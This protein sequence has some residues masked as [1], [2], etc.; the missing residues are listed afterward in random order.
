LPGPLE[1][2]GRP[3]PATRARELNLFLQ[4][5]QHA[6]ERRLDQATALLEEILAE[7]PLHVGAVEKLGMCQVIGQRWGPAIVTLERRIALGEAPASTHTNLALAY[8]QVGQ[9]ESSL[10]HLQ[11][12]IELDPSSR[13]A[14]ENLVRVLTR[15]GRVEEAARVR[16]LQE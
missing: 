6:E 14:R 7:N 8:E 2:T 4:A 10:G 5:Q 16:E 11:R 15:L 13:T 1:D 12:S 9:L 3:A